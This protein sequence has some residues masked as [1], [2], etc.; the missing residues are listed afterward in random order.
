VSTDRPAATR[1]RTTELSVTGPVEMV[2][3]AVPV[4]RPL[5]MAVIVTALIMIGLPAVLALGAAAG[6]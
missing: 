3:A 1:H 5:V 6:T 2:R 4:L